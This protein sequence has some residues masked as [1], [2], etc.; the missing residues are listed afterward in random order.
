MRGDGINPV[1]GDG[2]AL[3]GEGGVVRSGGMGDRSSPPGELCSAAD[4]FGG[5]ANVPAL[6]LTGPKGGVGPNVGVRLLSSA[7]PPT[8]VGVALPGASTASQICLKVPTH[9]SCTAM[10]SVPTR[11]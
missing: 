2:A 8:M 9:S 3:K 4:R 1:R 11:T 6:G 5:I 7:P 10:P